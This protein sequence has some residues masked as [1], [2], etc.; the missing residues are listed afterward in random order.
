MSKE[1]ILELSKKAEGLKLLYVE[2]NKGLQQQALKVFGKIFQDVT[3]SDS[4]EEALASFKRNQPH[5]VITDISMGKLNG[6]EMAKIMKKIEPSTKII[7]TSAYDDKEYLFEAIEANVSK[8]L[9]KPISIVTLIEAIEKVTDEIHFEKN[10]DLFE[11]YVQ[12]VFQYQDSMLILLR[13]EEILIANKK[14]LDFFSQD[15]LEDFREFFLGFDKFFLKH[16]NFLYN[17]DDIDWLKSVKEDNGRLFNVKIADKEGSSRHFI[18]KAYKIPKKEETFILSFDDITELNLLAVYDKNAMQQEKQKNQKKIIYNI[19]EIIKRN[20]SN[21]RVYNSYKGV[22][23]S[24]VAVLG[25]LGKD[26]A[27]LQTQ[28]IQQKA[29]KINNYLMIESELFPT[30]VICD[31]TKVDFENGQ[32]Y[33]KNYKFIDHNPSEQEYMRVEPEENHKVTMFFDGRKILA[34]TKILDVS[35]GGAKIL[36]SLVPAG[37]KVGDDVIVDMVFAMGA[38]PFIVNTKAKVKSLDELKKEFEVILIF[39]YDSNIKK[40]LTEYVANRQMALIREF[41]KL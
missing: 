1:K 33:I 36:L 40:L 29:I 8:F 34:D 23:I 13:G 10:K 38:K 5:V 26:E 24:N 17:H 16:N 31:V 18:L 20:N 32:V 2:D 12:D 4:A 3:T 19:F 9:K 37:F 35:V 22:M 39:E 27:V 28:Y 11:R 14:C 21:I 41:K 25:E 6:L 15:S 7:I 30:A